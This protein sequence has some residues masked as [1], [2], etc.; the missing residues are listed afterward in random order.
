MGMFDQFPYTNFHELNLDWILKSL[1]V[2]E[3]TMNQFVAINTLKYADPIQWNITT[4]Y[5]K[6][7][8]VIEPNTG[9]AYISVQPVP[10]GV[11]ITNTD[12]WTVVFN[13]S[14]FVVKMA[15]NLCAIYEPET[16]LTATV[17]SNYNDWIIWNDT[18]Y[19]NINPG[20]IVAGDTYVVGGNIEAFTVEDVVGHI[21]DLNTTDKSNLVAA[22]N[23]VLLA[24][25]TT[26]GDLADLDTT[27]KSNLVAAINEV[28]NTGGGS[29]A[30]IG[31]LNDL[32]TTDKSNVVAAINEVL[33][34]L[35]DTC[36]DLTNLTTTDNSNL[37][38]AINE[39]VS[40]LTTVEG[41]LTNLVDHNTPV[42]ILDCGIVGDGSDESAALQKV[43][44]GDYGNFIVIPENT[45]IHIYSP[46]VM[47][48]KMFLMGVSNL[49]SKIIGHGNIDILEIKN[50]D[51]NGSIIKNIRFDYY[52]GWD[53]T[54]SGIQLKMEA[55]ECYVDNCA[56][57][58]FVKAITINNSIDC[59]ITNCY[60]TEGNTVQSNIYGVGIEIGRSGYVTGIK[61]D[62]ITILS[63]DN[64]TLYNG[65]RILYADGVYF[66]NMLINRPR[67]CVNMT[68]NNTI[69]HSITFD[70]CILD[71]AQDITVDFYPQSGGRLQN[72]RFN[73]CWFST[74]SYSANTSLALR[75]AAGTTTQ[76]IQFIEC[77]CQ[78]AANGVLIDGTNIS[79]ITFIGNTFTEISGNVILV[80]NGNKLIF[81]GNI[82]SVNVETANAY[83]NGFNIQGGSDI[84]LSNNISNQAT[85]YDCII[86]VPTNLKYWNNIFTNTN[87]YDNE[88][89]AGTTAD[90][91]TSPYT[92]QPYYDTTLAK[93]IWW[94][95]VAWID[96]TGTPV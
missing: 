90:R 33:Q 78:S 92:G 10:A 19:R 87:L 24:L 47:T 65:I 62:G 34:D 39:I 37:V 22:I 72:I 53:A 51:A 80:N 91:P 41:I 56:F 83:V 54:T 77:C 20:G 93:P 86:G 63:D 43:L 28:N 6:N 71:Q 82:I 57:Y 9:T 48:T 85:T 17:P 79:D 46:V 8:I 49:T 96:A 35:L 60:M 55:S 61:I 44:D 64:H 89:N 70:S 3:K 59:K 50:I 14:E 12:Y 81:E 67:V 69:I 1:D 4:Q 40:A 27:D 52:G 84:V 88:H 76:F 32:N 18:L 36:G 75:G 38:A 31:D 11:S 13:L 95:S 74:N 29:I 94:N 7:T 73:K 66:S 21:Q 42:N 68:P 5:E 2:I 58:H 15:Q 16:T 30:L 23:E 25:T 26:A 45:E